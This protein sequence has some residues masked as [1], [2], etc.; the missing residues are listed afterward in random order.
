[1]RY[2]IATMESAR[3]SVSLVWELLR[4]GSLEDAAREAEEAIARHPER[5][6]LLALTADIHRRRHKLDEATALLDRARE[7]D[8]FDEAVLAAG[9]ELAFDRR[10]FREAAARFQELVD[11]RPNR[12]RLSRLVAAKN[13]LKEHAEAA[14]IARRALE[15]YPDDAW[16]LR[17]LA[18]AEAA[19]GRRDE[20]IAAYER[21][22]ALEPKDR[23]AYK[24]LMRLKTADA[25][26]EEAASALGGLMKAGGRDRNPHLKTLLADRLR[27]AGKLEQAVAE[28]ES[29]LALEPGDPYVLAQLGFTYKKLGR[30]REAMETLSQAFLAKP[31]DPYVRKSL[32]SLLTKRVELDR[33]LKLIDEAL[34]RHPHVKSLYGIRKRIARRAGTKTAGKKT[35]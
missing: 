23:F 32:E 26:P 25:S 34:K 12:Y 1:M 3:R 31:A 14:A 15:S 33:M 4:S 17:G 20:A 35:E 5:A 16:T 30:E 24:E 6:E 2:L 29:A 27:K 13:R 22:L 7:L 8:P 10:E 21:L 19:L 28:Y 11:R 9:A 18:T